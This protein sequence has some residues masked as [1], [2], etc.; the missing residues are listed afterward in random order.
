MPRLAINHVMLL[1]LTA[2]A[3]YWWWWWYKNSNHSTTPAS[4]PP[5]NPLIHVITAPVEQS[6]AVTEEEPQAVVGGTIDA[7]DGDTVTLT[8]P[9]AGTYPTFNHIEY[10]DGQQY[11]YDKTPFDRTCSGNPNCDISDFSGIVGFD[12][13][14]GATTKHFRASWTCSSSTPTPTQAVQ[15]DDVEEEGC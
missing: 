6:D 8:C 2:T 11:T 14:P 1:G 12:P 3:M 4:P 10:G 5:P 7:I 9:L 15:D 13:A